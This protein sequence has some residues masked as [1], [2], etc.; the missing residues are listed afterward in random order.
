M[1]GAATGALEVDIT[2]MPVSGGGVVMETSRV[3]FGPTALPTQYQGRVVELRGDTVVASV[4]SAGGTSLRLTIALQP[5]ASRQFT[6]AV[7]V[8]AASR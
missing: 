6:G 2:G 1:S 3:A 8:A 7:D 4:Q 5:D